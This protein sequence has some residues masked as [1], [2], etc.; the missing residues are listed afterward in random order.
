MICFSSR[1]WIR[2]QLVVRL[3]LCLYSICMQLDAGSSS[4]TGVGRDD[5]VSARRELQVLTRIAWEVESLYKHLDGFH[6]IDWSTLVD[7]DCPW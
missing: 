6:D 2:G 7:F 5:V 4:S 3:L 1:V